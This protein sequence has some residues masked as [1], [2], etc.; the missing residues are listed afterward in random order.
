MVAAK[1]GGRKTLA[2]RASAPTFEVVVM[3]RRGARH[4]VE[5]VRDAAV[6]VDAILA[7]EKYKLELVLTRVNSSW[8]TTARSARQSAGVCLEML[9]KARIGGESV[10]SVATARRPNAEC[11]SMFEKDAPVAERPFFQF[12]ISHIVLNYAFTQ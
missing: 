12:P 3:M 6:A 1:H 11:V 5:V 2:E 8:C 10:D 4:E 9:A 7:G